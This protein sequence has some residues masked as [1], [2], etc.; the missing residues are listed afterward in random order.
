MKF[1]V[2]EYA[3]LRDIWENYLGQ[4]YDWE[5]TIWFMNLVAYYPRH[6]IETLKLLSVGFLLGI[7][8]I[9]IYKT[10]EARKNKHIEEMINEVI[11]MI[12][13]NEI[14]KEEFH[15]ALHQKA[16]KYFNELP[17]KYKYF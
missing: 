6:N 7:F 9:P 11:K 16:T 5:L 12:K 15:Q 3:K 2:K 10:Y 4:C 17:D 8:S 14:S 1:T 13:M